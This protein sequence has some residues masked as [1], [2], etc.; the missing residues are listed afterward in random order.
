MKTKSRYVLVAAFC[1]GAL[2]AGAA[3]AA[4]YKS[5]CINFCYVPDASW[6]RKQDV[7]AVKLSVYDSSNS[8]ELGA[9]VCVRNWN[10]TAASCGAWGYSGVAFSGN[11]DVSLP[12]TAWSSA[13]AADFGYVYLAG[14]PNGSDVRCIEYTHP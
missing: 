13:T 3:S 12:L 2:S 1:V 6:F 8:S 9:K 11:K 14:I 10:S 5:M 4:S 7:T